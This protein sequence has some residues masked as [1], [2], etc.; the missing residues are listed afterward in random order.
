MLTCA[1]VTALTRPSHPQKLFTWLK[2][3]YFDTKNKD[4][5]LQ[6]QAL[7]LAVSDAPSGHQ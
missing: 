7:V 3:K 6:T 1:V 2:Y 5:P 4:K